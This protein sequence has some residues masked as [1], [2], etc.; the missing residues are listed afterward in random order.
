MYL[1]TTERRNKDGCVVRYVQLAHNQRV[2]GV[3]KAE[4][5]L[6]LGREDR[7]DRTVCAGWSARSTATSASPTPTAVPADAATPIGGGA[8]VDRVAPDG[9]GMAARRAVAATRVDAALRKVLGGRRFTTDVERVL[10]ALVANRAID[11]SSKL[12]AAEWV[13]HDVAIPGPGRRWTRIR[14]TGRWTCSSRPTPRPEVQEAVF[15][16]VA[17]LLNL[18]V[19]LLFF[20]TTSHL[21]R[22][23][24]RRRRRRCVPPIRA[25]QGPPHR[26][27][28]DRHRAGRDQGRDPGAVLVLARQH[29]RPAVLP[30]VHDGMRGLATR[31]GRHRRRPRVLLHREPGLPAPRRRALTSPGNGCGPGHPWSNR[32]CPGKAATPR[33]ADNLRVKEVRLDGAPDRRWV[34][35]HNPD[36]AQRQKAMR[37][38][39]LER[40]TIELDWIKTIR[41]SK[42]TKASTAKKSTGRAGKPST[43]QAAHRRPSARCVTTP[44]WA[45][46]YGS[47]PRAGS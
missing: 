14:R 4:V 30:E 38:A 7:L 15:F 34:I 19:D 45:G 18:E 11:P 6:N 47:C 36:E 20:D 32:H 2:E 28:P 40:I 46:G 39:A 43:D 16:A 44:P 41:T 26:P 25:L 3:T 33:S 10:F 24:H 1:R 22:T 9:G 27:A 5:L 8:E 29:Q 17:D 42:P 12:A 31:P 21:L 37:D 13:S 23:R 35:C